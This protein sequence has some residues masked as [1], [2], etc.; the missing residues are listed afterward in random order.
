MPNLPNLYLNSGDP[1]SII[2]SLLLILFLW[3]L[4]NQE[5]SR[6][7]DL[8][9][10]TSQ[11]CSESRNTIV[12]P[13]WW[14]LGLWW[15]QICNGSNRDQLL[16]LWLISSLLESLLTSSIHNCGCFGMNTL[17]LNFFESQTCAK[18]HQFGSELQR[19][20]KG[21]HSVSEY[22]LWIKALIDSL[23][24]IGF[25]V[26]PHEHI[27]VILDGLLRE[28]DACCEL[29]VVV[30]MNSRLDPYWVELN[31]SF[32][33]WSSRVEK[34]SHK[35]RLCYFSSPEASWCVSLCFCFLSVHC[36]SF[37]L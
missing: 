23:I 24:F 19:I 34:Q 33:K 36:F 28:C 18:V 21:S 37:M 2:T 4:M 3:N 27:D 25:C 20:K 17:I 7:C 32:Y 30:S 9:R 10:Q 22:L 26:L 31:I 15:N 29:L 35:Y 5:T 11:I 13:I 8:R 12:F 6:S 14:W 1:Y 16:F